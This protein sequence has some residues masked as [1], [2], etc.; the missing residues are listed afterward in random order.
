M[1]SYLPP[2]IFDQRLQLDYLNMHNSVLTWQHASCIFEFP[3]CICTAL[4]FIIICYFI[5]INPC[6]NNQEIS[7]TNTKAAFKCHALNKQ[8]T[9]V[10]QD[11][12][13]VL[14]FPELTRT[15]K[16]VSKRVTASWE[17]QNTKFLK[18][19]SN[20]LCKIVIPLKLIAVP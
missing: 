2:G 18:F 16:W 8:K 20:S 9:P 12:C 14:K 3:A 4:Y 5:I 17:Y 11:G 15:P 13:T 10:L 1:K 19:L 6:T 7:L